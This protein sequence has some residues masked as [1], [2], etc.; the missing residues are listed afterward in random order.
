MEKSI[1]ITNKYLSTEDDN[2][3]DDVDLEIIWKEMNYVKYEITKIEKGTDTIEV[4]YKLI[5]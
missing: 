5:N 2:F 4:F 1:T 3:L